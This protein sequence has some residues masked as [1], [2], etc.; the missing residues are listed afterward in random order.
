MAQE[1]TAQWAQLVEVAQEGTAQWAQPVEVTLLAR[2][3]WELSI[4][5]FGSAH[6][7][8]VLL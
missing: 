3:S 1:G 6:I 8:Y 4:G 2:C 5:E 7:L